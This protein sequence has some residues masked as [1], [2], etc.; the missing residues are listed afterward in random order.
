MAVTPYMIKKFGV[1]SVAKFCAVLG[2]IWGFV[3]GLALALG[4]GGMAAV[5]GRGG[6]GAGMGIIGLI[7]MI[8]LG[9]I[10]GF[11][12]GAIIAFIYNIVLGAIGGIEMDLEA[13]T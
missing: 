2:L 9:A 13:K 10:G 6:L 12:G 5:M 1:L 3:A 8:I 7:V 11:I 4:I